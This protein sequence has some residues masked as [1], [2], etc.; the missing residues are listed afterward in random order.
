MNHVRWKSFRIGVIKENNNGINFWSA[1]GYKKIK[2]VI[3]DFAE[4]K[5]IVNIMTSQAYNKL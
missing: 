2:E 1:L 5:H 3:M 4:K